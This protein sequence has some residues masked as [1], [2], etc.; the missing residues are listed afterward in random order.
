MSSSDHDSSAD[1]R[2]ERLLLDSAQSDE[3]PNDVDA[4][5][6]KFHAALNGVSLLAAGAS[7]ALAA[8]R[9][10][11]W[12]AAKWLIWGVLAG[13]ALSALSLRHSHQLGASSS[14]A[15]SAATAL[16]AVAS[17]GPAGPSASPAQAAAE[18]APLAKRVP[19]SSQAHARLSRGELVPSP[20]PGSTLSAQ[21]A[22]LDAARSALAAGAISDALRLSD[23]YRTDFA[24]G[25][26]AP[27]AEVVAIEALVEQ[28]QR[29]LAL[30]R[31]ARFLVRYPGDPHTARVKWLTR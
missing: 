12:L 19:H 23:K 20:L 3:L 13:S 5:W 24:N 17:G 14:S 1:Q 26:L 25:E 7:G 11:R 15:P 29:Q 16:P 8:R 31:A 18:P 6:H 27:E 28:G 2:F 10:Q 22:L 4:A 30:E 9:A 21:V